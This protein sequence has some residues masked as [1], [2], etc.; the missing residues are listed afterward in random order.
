VRAD[1]ISTRRNLFM[2]LFDIY[3]HIIELNRKE[4]VNKYDA[5]TL[6]LLPAGED[7]KLQKDLFRK[8]AVYQHLNT[9]IMTGSL[10]SHSN[11]TV[12]RSF[13]GI[14]TFRM[15]ATS[16]VSLS[17]HKRYSAKLGSGSHTHLPV[18]GRDR[19]RF[20]SFSGNNTFLSSY[21]KSHALSQTF[22]PSGREGHNS[23]HVQFRHSFPFHIP[24]YQSP[25]T[26]PLN[27]E[28]MK[29]ILELLRRVDFPHYAYQFFLT[30]VTNRITAS[31]VQ[32]LFV[33]NINPAWRNQPPIPVSSVDKRLIVSF[34]NQLTHDSHLF[35]TVCFFVFCM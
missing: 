17:P 3:M 31:L 5:L 12:S 34:M 19:P 14:P 27:K 26:T 11:H 6:A 9:D 30:P 24:R 32:F 16:V 20:S 18:V 28:K 13:S 29:I 2:L 25:Q 7:D 1:G 35:N 4:E 22:S 23:N 33:D 15:G 10:G 21:F 8:S